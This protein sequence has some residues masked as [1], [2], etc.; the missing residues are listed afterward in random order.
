M[1]L[2]SGTLSLSFPRFWSSTCTFCV[3]ALISA[4]MRATSH[5]HLHCLESQICQSRFT[6]CKRDRLQHLRVC[7]WSV[8]MRRTVG[9]HTKR[10]RYVCRD[11]NANI[12]SAFGRFKNGIFVVRFYVHTSVSLF[13][14]IS[15]FH[16]HSWF[17]LQSAIPLLDIAEAYL[18][19]LP[20]FACRIQDIS[21]VMTDWWTQTY[22][23]TWSVGWRQLFK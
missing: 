1:S 20:S 9:L 6:P 12:K 21:Y 2:Q 11:K 19:T 22:S 16:F 7:V 5:A 14:E 17:Q 15:A 8:L 23:C 3:S 13:Y 10:Y 18:C 4:H